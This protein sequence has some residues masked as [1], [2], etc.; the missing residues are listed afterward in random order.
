MQQLQTWYFSPEQQFI[1]PCLI[2]FYTVLKSYTK[3]NVQTRNEILEI[4][5]G[6]FTLDEI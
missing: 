1:R 3:G 2:L 5:V 4:V 6:S